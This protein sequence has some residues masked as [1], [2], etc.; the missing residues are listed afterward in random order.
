MINND[1]I[2]TLSKNFIRVIIHHSWE[3]GK[4]YCDVKKKMEN[5]KEID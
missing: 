5:E 1:R 3:V 2:I 4:L